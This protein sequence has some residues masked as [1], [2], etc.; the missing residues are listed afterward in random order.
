[1]ESPVIYIDIEKELITP[2]GKINLVFK[3][4]IASGELI[5]L[6]GASG[7]GK[8]TLLRMLAGLTK[9][10]KGSIKYGEKV[11]FD[12]SKGIHIPSQNRNIGFMFQDYA[13]FPNM[14][15]EGNIRF[16]QP[17]Q[18]EEMVDQLLELFG[19]TGFR[20]QKPDKLSGGQKQRVALARALARKPDVLLLDEPFSSL[21]YKMRL[22]IQK[23]IKKAYQFKQTTMIIVSHD[24]AEIL[25]L[26]ERIICIEDG[27]I[28]R[29]GTPKE[30]FADYEITNFE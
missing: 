14:T 1:M 13:L 22:S 10:D 15:I 11:W 17:V 6:F 12:S 30:V 8:T 3:S 21:D 4:E 7:E 27:A 16:A 29:T 5:A 18:D 23:E 25:R 9:P 2:N 26:A 28:V 19:L 20:K 24:P